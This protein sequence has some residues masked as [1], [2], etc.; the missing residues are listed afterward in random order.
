MLVAAGL[1]LLP[2]WGWAD[3]VI[4]ALGTGASAYKPSADEKPSA[5]AMQIVRRMN[6]AFAPFC[7][8]RCPEAAMLR[9]PTAPNLMLTANQEGAKLV[10]S[11]Q[12][13]ASVYGKYGDSGIMALLAHVYGH[14]IDEVTQQAW[15][16]A[17][18][19]PELRADAWA[20][21]VL[22]KSSPPSSGLTQALAALAQYPPPSETGWTRRAAAVR[23]G[24]THCGGETRAFDAA[25]RGMKAK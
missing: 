5:D 15:L 11:P 9:N 10:Y 20:G 19:N 1:L 18:W 22:A 25:S 14:A 24:F 12:F 7:L 8:P 3:D 6:T 16:P 23:L 4:C 13:F 21:C 2:A 17:A